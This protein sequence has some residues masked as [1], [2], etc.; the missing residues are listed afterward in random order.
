MPPAAKG[1]PGLA[2]LS[3]GVRPRV[4]LTDLEMMG[5]HH[6]SKGQCVVGAFGRIGNPIASTVEPGGYVML[7]PLRAPE[8]PASQGGDQQHVH[9]S[10]MFLA[11]L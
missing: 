2:Y 5:R 7:S 11:G 9:T 8:S 10:P 4:L 6:E 3:A 1:H